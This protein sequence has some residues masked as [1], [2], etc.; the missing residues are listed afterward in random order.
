VFYTTGDMAA[1]LRVATVLLS[2]LI[3]AAYP[4]SGQSAA[5]SDIRIDVSAL[6]PQVGERVPDFALTDQYG[7]IRTLQSILGRQ[8]AVLVFVR[9]TDWCPY[10]KTQLVELQGRVEELEA[11]GLGLAAISYD[12]V[13]VHAG[14]SR[15]RG[16][17][18][19]LLA[20]VGSATIAEYGLLNPVPEMALGPEKDDP[21]VQELVQRYVSVVN[22]TARMVGIAFPGT[23]ILDRQGR[24]VSRFFEDFYIERTTMAN[25]LVR[26]GAGNEEIAATAA[27]T[28]HFDLVTYPSDVSIAAGNRFALVLEV[29]PKPGMHIYAPGA[30]GYRVIALTVAPQP[31]LRIEPAA[32][33]SSEIYHFQPLDER[34]PVYRRPFR[35][36]QEIVLEGHPQAQAAFRGLD[37]LTISGRLE[38]QACSSTICYNPVSLPLSWTVDLRPLV[39]R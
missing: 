14:F 37:H 4:A 27:S 19:P 10:C 28:A 12:P 16:I 39:F 22:P 30:A 11:Q 2:V 18:F 33:P 20:D 29:T 7:E 21:A 5:P 38:Y 24:V 13:D 31:F 15:Q 32:Y 9:S 17:T 35:L 25:L 8:G 6:G 34:V 26:R 3:G 23:F 36:V 1:I